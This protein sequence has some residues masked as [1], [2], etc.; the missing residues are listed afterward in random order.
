MPLVASVLKEMLGEGVAVAIAMPSLMNDELFPEERQYIA[1]AVAKRQ[2]EFGTARICARKA[3]A[4]LDVAPCPL[5]PN[6]DRSPR[7]PQ[8]I[9]GSISHTVGI[10]AVAVARDAFVAGLGLDLEEDT[11]LPAELEE[12]IC[13]PFE[14]SRFDGADRCDRGRHGKLLFSTKEAFYKC[15]YRSTETLIDFQD[16]ELKFDTRMENF[17]VARLTRQGGIWNEVQRI[18]GKI[19]YAS[20]LVI[21]I[22]V[23]NVTSR[24]QK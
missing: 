18:Q 13:T 15:Q 12:F 8:G 24:Q 17:S 7:W 16:V 22:A 4:E 9:V 21:T 5:V 3:L 23:L 14:R 1:R 11:P 6:V 2:A 20:G 10:C 19:R